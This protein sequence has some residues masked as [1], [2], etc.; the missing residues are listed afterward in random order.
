[1][2][3]QEPFNP[4]KNRVWQCVLCAIFRSGLYLYAKGDSALKTMGPWL[5]QPPKKPHLLPWIAI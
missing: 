2:N 1:M 3:E 5:P 4:K